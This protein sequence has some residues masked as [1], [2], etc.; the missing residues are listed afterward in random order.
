MRIVLLCATAR[1]R[2]VLERLAVRLRGHELIV[3]SFREGAVEPPYLDGIRDQV[4]GM[5]GRFV[6]ARDVGTLPELAQ[7]FDLLLAV[8]WRYLV[9]RSVIER[10]RL[11]AFVIHDSLLPAY[12]GFSPTVWALINGEQQTGATLFV[13]SDEVDAGD[14]VD[15]VAVPIGPDETIAAVMG[16]VT[17]GY[18]QLIDANLDDLLAGRARRTPQDHARATFACK[19]TPADNLISWNRSTARVFNLIRAVTHPYAGAYTFLRGRIL[20]V[21]DAARTSSR[22]WVGGMPGRVVE[23]LPGTGSIVLTGD[24]ELLV[25]DVQLEGEERV[26]AS[27]VLSSLTM[28]LRETSEEPRAV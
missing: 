1:G 25:T 11:G 3:V 15:Q 5:G 28:T 26:C 2:A 17:D 10:A 21:W 20:R 16:R 23:V 13:M 22:A 19:R 9:P 14:I 6:E 12:R 7:G 24:G 8:S 27:K 4:L 18:L